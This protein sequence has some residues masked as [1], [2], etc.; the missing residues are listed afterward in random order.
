MPLLSTFSSLSFH[1]DRSNAEIFTDA[2][3]FNAYDYELAE[4][5]YIYRVH[6]F[7]RVG[8]LTKEK[9]EA[10]QQAI[11]DGTI[12]RVILSPLIGLSLKQFS[13]QHNIEYLIVGG[14]GGG[15]ARYHGGGGG[16]GG[17]RS[18]IVNFP[19]KVGP[20]N[21]Y[22]VYVGDGGAG[23][24]SLSGDPFE[25]IASEKGD[26]SSVFD[27]ESAGGGETSRSNNHDG[28][29]GGGEHYSSSE[30]SRGKGNVP[31]VDP[32]QGNDG[33]L[34]IGDIVGSR[35]RAGGGGGGAV[36][37]GKNGQVNFGGA[38][39]DGK[40]SI[41]MGFGE[42]FAGGGSGAPVIGGTYPN[43][44]KGGGG[45]SGR[46]GQNGV[47]N[48]GGGGGAGGSTRSDNTNSKGG[49]GGSGIVVVRY[50][51]AQ[52]SN[53][54]FNPYKNSGL[55]NG[56]LGQLE[57]NRAP[58]IEDLERGFL[59]IAPN[60]RQSVSSIDYDNGDLPFTNENYGLLF[61]GYF[62]AP[63]TG[64][65][66]FYITSD[67][68]SLMWIGNRAEKNEYKD[69]DNETNPKNSLIDNPSG[70]SSVGYIHLIK[71]RFYAIRIIHVQYSGPGYLKFE[72]KSPSG[73][74]TTNLS[75]HFRHTVSGGDGTLRNLFDVD[76][77]LINTPK[78][79]FTYGGYLYNFHHFNG[80]LYALIASPNQYTALKRW[81]PTG[82]LTLNRN[83]DELTD[84]RDGHKATYRYLTGTNFN[85]TAVSYCRSLSINGYDDWYLPS[86][87]ELKKMWDNRN[88]IGGFQNVDANNSSLAA[89]HWSTAEENA[90]RAFGIATDGREDTDPKSDFNYVRPI[91]RQPVYKY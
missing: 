79:N 84:F 81:G 82:N 61:T 49:K 47:A 43:G 87:I 57:S 5:G 68:R 46:I 67:D 74:K 24:P 83:Y 23:G 80:I 42:Y 18:D 9:K 10:Q 27:I 76:L 65:Y 55:Q 56:L 29:S 30:S 48:T 11:E 51:I 22:D 85:D 35:S 89:T 70:S 44:G 28:G 58:Y 45:R 14:G 20:D 60:S 54:A 78:G 17:F 3:S 50:P 71:D 53:D 72:W 25:E 91:R 33:G 62:K 4:S 88:F 1:G 31:A 15:G 86:Y 12:N 37:I 77:D 66:T 2:E 21:I 8:T 52:I 32:P 39:G 73:T 7:T 16:A 13:P 64:T 19:L 41:I 40:M 90:D 36:G 38:G 75:S 63:E 26:P 34:G 69:K 6:E 59:S